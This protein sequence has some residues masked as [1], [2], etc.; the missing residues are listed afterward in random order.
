[1]TYV[2]LVYLSLAKGSYEAKLDVNLMERYKSPTKKWERMFGAIIPS[3]A[4]LTFVKCF[5]QHLT[6]PCKCYIK[7]ITNN[8]FSTF[9]LVIFLM[10]SIALRS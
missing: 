1:M 8:V 3:L 4:V 6:G 5:R 9:Y 7:A 10:R 2:L